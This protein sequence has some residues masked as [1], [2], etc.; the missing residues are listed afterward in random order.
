MMS[1]EVPRLTKPCVSGGDTCT[2]A[3][4]VLMRPFAVKY[5]IWVSEI[6][7]YSAC[8]LCT[9]ARTSDPTKKQRWR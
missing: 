8:P 6:G 7:T 2:K 4:S 3:T 1:T 9:S 5:G